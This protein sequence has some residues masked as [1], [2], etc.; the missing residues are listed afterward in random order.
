[1]TTGISVGKDQNGVAMYA[2][3]TPETQQRVL[4]AANTEAHFTVGN[5][6]DKYFLVFSYE[7]GATVHVD[8]TGNT[9]TVPALNTFSSTTTELLPQVRQV[10]AGATVSMITADT[11]AAV[12]VGIYGVV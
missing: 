1:M 7:P 3:F 5:D 9:A 11:T 12:W 2:P 6:F 4:L 10:F 8:L